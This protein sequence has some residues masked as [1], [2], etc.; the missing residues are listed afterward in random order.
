[1]YRKFK[2]AAIA[3]IT[4]IIM[5]TNSSSNSDQVIR[6]GSQLLD[7]VLMKMN[8]SKNN[9]LKLSEQKKFCPKCKVARSPLKT[10]T[11]SNKWKMFW[12]EQLSEISQGVPKD[13]LIICQKRRRKCIDILLMHIKLQLSLQQLVLMYIGHHLLFK[14]E[15]KISYAPAA[16]L[17]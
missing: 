7:Q 14:E 9:Q 2:Y 13:G 4:N 12:E 10:T 11:L 16:K 3:S 5:S 1:M 17:N 15:K 8:K 6:N